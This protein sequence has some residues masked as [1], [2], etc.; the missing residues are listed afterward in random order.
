MVKKIKKL[1]VLYNTLIHLRPIQIY[2]RIFLLLRKR[3]INT[4]FKKELANPVTHINW[5]NLISPNKSFSKKNS[6]K[7]LNKEYVFGSQIDWNYDKYGKLWTYNLNYF[8]FLLQDDITKEQGLG[9]IKQYLRDDE[10]LKDGKEPYPISL[11]GINWVKFLSIHRVEDS[12]IDQ[13]LYNHY[14]VLLHNLEYHLLGNHLLENGFSLLFGAYFF[15]DDTLYKNGLKVLKKE[16][17]EQILKD[18]AHFELSPMYHQIML[19]RVL[20]CIQLI[21]LNTWKDNDLL[22]FLEKV[23]LKMLSWLKE[24]TFNNGDIPMVNDSSYGIAPKTE[25]LLNY[26]LNLGLNPLPIKLSDSGYRMFKRSKF[27]LFIDV[28]NVGP[29]YQPAHAHSDTFNF[30]LYVNNL[31]IF[32]D[33]GVSTYEKNELRQTE[34][35]TSS[36]NTVQVGNIEQTQV[37]GGFRV[38]K[39][40]K[41]NNIIESD[42][43]VEASHTGY[44]DINL[45]HSRSF[46]LNENSVI[47]KD[48]LTGTR[49]Y[50]KKAYFHL[51]P[52]ITD[53]CIENSK[54]IIN[55]KN[56]QLFFKGENIFIE[57]ESY[58][59]AIGFNKTLEGIKL[60]VL[61]ESSLST[62]IQL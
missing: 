53:I 21:K 7:F 5:I 61:F 55:D 41:I 43:S 37:W 30:I 16:L 1:K 52:T 32:V 49:E 40:A 50:D 36:H 2:Y 17:Q 22:S 28:G 8:D 31:P 12:N 45:I 34:R 13:Q 33:T 56:I 44:K 10:K 6:F 57:K 24:V 47:I 51:H 26:G 23:A 27:E 39:R 3:I 18:G 19:F 14:T 9:L 35:S 4:D 58:R 54:V 29:L 38:A 62:K 46:I 25:E 59:F 42:N 48:N 11:R 15:K 20:D 60:K